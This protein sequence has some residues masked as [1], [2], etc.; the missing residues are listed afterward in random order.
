[1]KFLVQY[2]GQFYNAD[3]SKTVRSIG[4]KELGLKTI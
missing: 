1:L 2:F 3:F 4:Y